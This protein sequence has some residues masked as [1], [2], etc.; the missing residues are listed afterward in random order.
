M[1]S[2]VF[3]GL[4]DLAEWQVTIIVD[5]GSLRELGDGLL[6]SKSVVLDPLLNQLV[7][8]EASGKG[9]SLKY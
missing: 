5:D 2:D 4:W 7:V 1:W 3:Q 8:T 9:H 6:G